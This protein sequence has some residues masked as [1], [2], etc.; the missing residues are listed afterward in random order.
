[1]TKKDLEHIAL[2]SRLK[3]NESEKAMY[4]R[5]LNVILNYFQ[6]LACPD[7]ENVQPTTHVLPLQNIFREDWV[8]QHISRQDALANCPDRQGDYFR[9]PKIV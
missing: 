5:Q 3:L 6:S 8:G 9:V 2:L 1:M 4:A 7:T